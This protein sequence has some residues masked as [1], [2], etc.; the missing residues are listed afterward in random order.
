MG[1]RTSNWFN[2]GPTT[3]QTE[4]CYFRQSRRGTG[5]KFK[6]HHADKW[7]MMNME[8]YMVH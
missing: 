8:D 4:I 7:D 6:K 2:R 3:S 5:R 1:R